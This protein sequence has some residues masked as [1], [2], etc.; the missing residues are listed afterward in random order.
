M[1]DALLSGDSSQPITDRSFQLWEDQSMWIKAALLGVVVMTFAGPVGAFE[2]EDLAEFVGFTIIDASHVDGEFEGADFDKTVRL[3]NGM[4]FEFLEY[5]YSYSYRPV[6]IVLA[7]HLSIEEQ[8]KLNPK[9]TPTRP[10][11]LY[12]LLIEDEKYSV[13]RIR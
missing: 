1:W 2:A 13:M 7:M 4:I 3:E 9:R 11:T 10:L 12:Y 6:A 5:N 8:R